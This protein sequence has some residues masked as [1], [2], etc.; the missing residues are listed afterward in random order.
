[1][2]EAFKQ[3]SPHGV[4]AL[5][6][7]FPLQATDTVLSADAAC[8]TI[9]NGI[10]CLL[11]KLDLLVFR[12]GIK[13]A[14]WN[15]IEMHIAIADMSVR[16]SE[17][18]WENLQQFRSASATNDASFESWTDMSVRRCLPRNAWPSFMASRNIQRF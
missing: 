18:I 3:F 5:L 9:Q 17:A 14:F 13:I 4:N 16:N 12:R 7:I 2:L 15:D 8:V 10:D 11:G 6:E 1:M